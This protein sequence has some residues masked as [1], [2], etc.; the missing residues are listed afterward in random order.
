MDEVTILETGP[1]DGLQSAAAPLPL[2]SRLEFIQRLSRAGLKRIEMGAFVSPKWIPQMSGTGELARMVFASQKAGNIPADVRF[3][4]LIPNQKGLGMALDSGLR[5][6]AVFAACSDTFSKKNINRSVEESLVIYKSVCREALSH[7]LKVRAYLSVCFFCPFEGPIPPERAIL[8]A[9]K[10]LDMGAYEVAIS[11]TAGTA[12]PAQVQ[13]LLEGLSKKVSWSQIACHFHDLHGLGL[14][15]VWAAYEAGVRSFDGSAGGL[16]GC[17]YAG[18]V[19]GNTPTEGL[20]LLLQAAKS[21][22]GRRFQKKAPL[23]KPDDSG[24]AGAQ[25]PAAIARRVIETA[26]WLEA[27]LGCRLPSPLLRSP[28]FSKKKEGRTSPELLPLQK[29]GGG[30]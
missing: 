4:A 7:G 26:L 3:S 5:E 6:A 25:D 24:A 22:A 12:S 20:L 1:R 27:K 15:N 29:T 10:L 28:F 14:A 2:S 21:I 13:D 11:D 9:E 30:G 18:S 23:S 16:G 8:L 19:A 17:P